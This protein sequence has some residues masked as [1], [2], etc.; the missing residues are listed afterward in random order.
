[1]FAV[2]FAHYED[3][4]AHLAADKDGTQ[5]PASSRVVDKSLPLL[6]MHP[7][8]HPLPGGC[9]VVAGGHIFCS[10]QQLPE[11]FRA[12][13]GQDTCEDVGG[14]DTMLAVEFGHDDDIVALHDIDKE[15][16][17]Q[18]VSRCHQVLPTIHRLCCPS[19]LGSILCLEDA[20]L[21]LE[22]TFAAAAINFMRCFG[23]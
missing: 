2:E 13:V 7:Q 10:C 8:N 5:L 22:D 12:I 16:T 1:M 14:D 23:S 6:S 18:S 11:V 19:T 15:A 4:V 17:L 3:I 21:L 20:P 9:C